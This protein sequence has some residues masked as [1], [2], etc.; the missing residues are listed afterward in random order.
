MRAQSLNS[1]VEAKAIR[2]SSVRVLNDIES[3]L[4]SKDNWEMM[5]AARTKGVILSLACTQ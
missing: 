3:L 5:R 1:Q 2:I 4:A